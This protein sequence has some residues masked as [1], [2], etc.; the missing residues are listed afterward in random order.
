MTSQVPK[1]SPAGS[2]LKT[3]AIACVF[4]LCAFLFVSGLNGCDD[5]SAPNI[6]DARD[7]RDLSTFTLDEN[8]V[9]SF[10]AEMSGIT[11][12][13]NQN[14]ND[15]ELSIIFD[16][17]PEPPVFDIELRARRTPDTG[18]PDFERPG[19]PESWALNELQIACLEVPADGSPVVLTTDARTADDRAAAFEFGITAGTPE[20]RTIT[21]GG[22]TPPELCELS[23]NW[24]PTTRRIDLTLTTTTRQ[25]LPS[26][27]LGLMFSMSA[28]VPA[29]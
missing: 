2:P 5:A 14:F 4:F 18:T 28:I 21:P 15:I 6:T 23:A 7:I 19:T 24:N 13:P 20:R 17:A 16:S 27:D 1:I 26:T 10:Q 9:E 11:L 12:D 8:D 25:I 22:A 3:H 29:D